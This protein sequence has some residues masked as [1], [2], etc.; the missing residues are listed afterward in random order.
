[1]DA[2]LPRFRKAGHDVRLSLWKAWFQRFLQKREPHHILGIPA[3]AGIGLAASMSQTIPLW[4][5]YDYTSFAC[6]GG[7]FGI[8]L[9][10]KYLYHQYKKQYT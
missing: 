5:K 7:H 9:M 8:R 4:T 2:L 10:M 1:V 3:R 6:F